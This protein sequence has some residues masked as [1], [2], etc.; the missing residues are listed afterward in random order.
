MYAQN[1]G[2]IKT[3]ILTR[4]AYSFHLHLYFTHIIDMESMET[5]SDQDQRSMPSIQQSRKVT[6]VYEYVSNRVN[7]LKKGP[8]AQ[9]AT[10]GSFHYLIQ[11]KNSQS[12]T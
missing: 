10:C 1:V 9:Q 11:G 3:D 6:V 4:G 5:A 2:A 8:R 7:I 12:F